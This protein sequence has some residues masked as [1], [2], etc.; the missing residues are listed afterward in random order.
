[1]NTPAT[2]AETPTETPP[3]SPPTQI[4]KDE[5]AIRETIDFDPS[6]IPEEFNGDAEAFVK[7]W[8]S[9]RELI[10]RQGKELGELRPKTPEQETPP[11]GDTAP[12][13]TLQ[14]PK[15][16]EAETPEGLGWD[17]LKS[18]FLQNGGKLTDE[19]RERLRTHNKMTDA[20]IDRWEKYGRLEQKQAT[21]AAA[22]LVGG[23]ENLKSIVTWAGKKLSDEE[24]ESVNAALAGPGAQTAL[25]GLQARYQAENTEPSPTPGV[26]PGVNTGSATVEPYPTHEAMAAAMKDPR[27]NTD[28]DYRKEVGM[29][30][31]ETYRRM[32]T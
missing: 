27:Y 25:L 30:T 15:P 28:P 1:M 24:L 5:A 2:P 23:E 13:E 14:I 7:S 10:A 32:A 11:E 18:E 22:Q 8:R 31:T 12:L 26:T 3:S 20:D 19:T 17:S 29:R 21:E 9:Q 4:D 16:E 6:V